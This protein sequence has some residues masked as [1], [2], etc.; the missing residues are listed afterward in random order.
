MS[1][2]E[3]LTSATST[4]RLGDNNETLSKNNTNDDTTT[5]TSPANPNNVQT[6]IRYL[7][8]A[9]F[10][11]AS[12][13]WY[14][15]PPPDP[16]SNEQAANFDHT[17]FPMTILDARPTNTT[18]PSTF[19]LDTHGFT[20]NP[21]STDP[22]LIQKIRTDI[23]DNIIRDVYY[24]QVED[25][26]CKVTGA[27]KA[28]VFDHLVRQQPPKSEE[29]YQRIGKETIMNAPLQGA[30]VDQS[31]NYGFGFL[32][33][34]LRDN[35]PKDFVCKR[36]QIVNVWR[37]LVD[38]VENFPL[39]V[40]DARTLSKITLIPA[41]TTYKIDT[42]LNR[43]VLAVNHDP[44]HQWYYLPHQRQDEAIFIKCFDTRDDVAACACHTSFINPNA[45]EDAPLRESIEIRAWVFYQG[46]DESEQVEIETTEEW[47]NPNLKF[48]TRW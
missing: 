4:L 3:T 32:N 45:S 20:F 10:T 23:E 17:P 46:E 41:K 44:A 42:N 33:K 26:L 15:R 7:D 29:Y 1:T 21:I 6:E 39:A 36:A 22:E 31:R 37:P 34:M 28:L 11:P 35:L 43:E 16:S 2:V 8:P 9:I 12:K 47:W 38:N 25:L 40:L 30:H 48:T 18:L 13:L 27:Q 5:K 14:K 19:T 24:N